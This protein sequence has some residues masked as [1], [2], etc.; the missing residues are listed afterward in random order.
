MNRAGVE[1][2]DAEGGV[3][4]GC[5]RRDHRQGQVGGLLPVVAAGVVS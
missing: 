5:G 3:G 1:A 2:G 4:R